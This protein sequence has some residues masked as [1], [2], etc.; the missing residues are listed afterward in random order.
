MADSAEHLTILRGHGVVEGI[1]EGEAIVT[2]QAFAFSHGVDPKTGI[3]TDLRHELKGKSIAGRILIYPQGRG[4]TTGDLWMLELARC[5]KSPAAIINVETD[6]I[7]V[8]GAVL[9][10]LTYGI[11]IP[12]IEKL[13]RN[14]LDIIETGDYLRVDASR[15]VVEIL[16]K[17]HHAKV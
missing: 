8:A 6:P 17:K 2:K 15:G 3:V 13:D 5:G 16:D 7:T 11:T 14:P 4:S 12:I 10:R 1:A 9:S